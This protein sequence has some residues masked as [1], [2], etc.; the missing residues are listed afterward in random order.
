M[1]VKDKVKKLHQKRAFVTV[2]DHKKNFPNSLE[3][4]LVN[5]MK[6]QIGVILKNILDKI[7]S[8]IRSKTNLIQ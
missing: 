3:C 2:K 1:S 8:S 5:T 6:S 7:T 4:R